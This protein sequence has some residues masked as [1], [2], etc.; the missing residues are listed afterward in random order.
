ML[1]VGARAIDAALNFD[2]AAS[3]FRPTSSSSSVSKVAPIAVE[4]YDSTKQSATVVDI[5][6]KQNNTDRKALRRGAHDEMIASNAYHRTSL[7][8]FDV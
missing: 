3:N 8:T 5:K 4:D 7:S 1:Q 6:T 2:S